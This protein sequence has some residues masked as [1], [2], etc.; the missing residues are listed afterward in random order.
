MEALDEIEARL[1]Q[2]RELTEFARDNNIGSAEAEGLNDRLR[3]M[4]EEVKELDKK[5]RVF[6]MDHQ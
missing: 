3:A 2:M 6:W 4:Q 5:T 1:G